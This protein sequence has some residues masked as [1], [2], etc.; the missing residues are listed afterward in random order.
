MHHLAAITARI[1]LV[2]ARTHSPTHACIASQQT[3]W[4][5]TLYKPNKIPPHMPSPYSNHHQHAPC[6]SINTSTHTH[7][8]PLAT[9]TV[10]MRLVHKN[11]HASPRSN[12]SEHAACAQVHTPTNCP[13]VSM[14]LVHK[15]TLQRIALQ[16][17]PWELALFVSQ[18]E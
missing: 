6:T 10:S 14:Q 9:I 16:E 2:Q 8:S 18:K 13:S 17:W 11:T 15:Y 4:A 7:A 12:H 1:C 3:Q 5:C